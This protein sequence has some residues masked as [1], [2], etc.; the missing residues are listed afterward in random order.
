M[1]D[2]C[3]PHLNSERS[4]HD[5]PVQTRATPS[6]LPDA[7]QHGLYRRLRWQIFLGIFI[8]YAGYYLVRK[9][10]SLAMPYLVEQGFSRGD[11]GFAMSG[12]AIAYGLSKFLMGAVSDRS[13]PRVF[14]SAAWCCPPPCSC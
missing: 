13:N 9:N 5:Q 12:V 3:C 10:F 7:Q 4:S 2:G 14:L 11:L 1:A 8:G 6:P